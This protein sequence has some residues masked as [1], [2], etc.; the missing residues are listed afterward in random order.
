MTIYF[1]SRHPGA[2]E[3][4][5]G[6]GIAVDQVLTHFDPECVEPDD[7]VLGTLP[8]HLV[9]RVCARG[10]RYLHLSLEVPPEWRGR[11]LS[12]SDLRACG[13]RLE[14]YRVMAETPPA[15]TAPISSLLPGGSK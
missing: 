12:A 1:I 15:T 7:V 9:A 4:A 11:E 8:I 14:A 13:A 6:E 2:H 10:G 3:W 5:A